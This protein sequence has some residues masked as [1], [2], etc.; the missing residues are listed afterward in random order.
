MTPIKKKPT[1]VIPIWHPT[2]PLWERVH[3]RPL[4]QHVILVEIRE[5][6]L[7]DHPDV[8]NY[9]WQITDH[10]ISP[11]WLYTAILWG[12]IMVTKWGWKGGGYNTKSFVIISVEIAM[13]N[14]LST[15][16][17]YVGDLAS[18]ARQMHI[19]VAQMRCCLNIIVQNIAASTIISQITIS[20]NLVVQ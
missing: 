9:T 15:N 12:S 16:P 20:T 1:A 11:W 18:F 2:R 14:L 13:K 10:M 8:H 5:E 17:I 3:V 19:L 6:L 7:Q 4:L